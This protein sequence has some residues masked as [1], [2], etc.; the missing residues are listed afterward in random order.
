[1]RALGGASWRQG[2]CPGFQE[3]RMPVGTLGAQA[4][5]RKPAPWGGACL[6]PSLLGSRGK[7]LPSR[8]CVHPLWK[9]LLWAG[10]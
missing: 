7:F 3:A 8:A 4:Q 10:R 6:P 1:M 9:G 2:A 5:P